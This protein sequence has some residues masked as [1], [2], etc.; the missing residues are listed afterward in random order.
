M[1]SAA[2]NI[3]VWMMKILKTVNWK[4]CQLTVIVIFARQEKTTAISCALKWLINLKYVH[5]CFVCEIQEIKAQKVNKKSI[6]CLFIW[7]QTW[8]ITRTKLLIII[9][10]NTVFCEV[11]VDW[12]GHIDFYFLW[13][14]LLGILRC[15]GDH[16]T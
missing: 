14:I 6:L 5:L 8:R 11:T 15:G 3:L 7:L 10:S 1:Y 12:R 2:R 16:T 13:H 4:I 9:W